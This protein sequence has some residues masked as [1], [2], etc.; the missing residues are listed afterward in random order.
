MML[1]T[2]EQ[3]LAA[4]FDAAKGMVLHNI[5]LDSQDGKRWLLKGLLALYARQTEDEK[6]AELT[7][8]LNEKGFNSADSFQLSGF[9]RQ[10]LEWQRSPAL[11]RKWESP[12][13]WK[14]WMKLRQRMRKYAGQL[15]R[16]AREKSA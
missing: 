13:S 12:L 9:S 11:Q 3:I 15:T 2:K 8:H 14:Q 5:M 6:S 1:Y 7:K 4:E 10:V 16:I